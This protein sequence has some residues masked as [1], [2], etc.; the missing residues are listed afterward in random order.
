MKRRVEG[1]A[2]KAWGEGKELL[3]RAPQ[4]NDELLG[5]AGG[6]LQG[7][8]EWRGRK[9][10]EGREERGVGKGGKA[11]SSCGRPHS[12]TTN[13]SA[14]QEEAGGGLQRQEVWGGVGG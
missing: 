4:Q 11:S 3:W 2:L 12:R 13:L 8:M 1:A 10:C 5:G 14:R 9:R 6:G 7:G